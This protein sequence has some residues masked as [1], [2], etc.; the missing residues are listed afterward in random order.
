MIRT[1]NGVEEVLADAE[2]VSLVASGLMSLPKRE[3]NQKHFWSIGSRVR[4]CEGLTE[5][6]QRAINAEREDSAAGMLGHKRGSS[7]VRPKKGSG[8]AR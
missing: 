1:A 2:E 5:A 8:G 4:K 6:I 7:P 3:S